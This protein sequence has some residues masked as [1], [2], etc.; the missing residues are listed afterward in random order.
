MI[1]DVEVEVVSGGG[2][3]EGAAAAGGHE[4]AGG[5]PRK[6]LRLISFAVISMQYK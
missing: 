1:P 5:R 6:R 3:D 2:G 4:V